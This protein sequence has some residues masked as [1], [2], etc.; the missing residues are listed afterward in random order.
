MGFPQEQMQF[1]CPTPP[2]LTTLSPEPWNHLTHFWHYNIYVVYTWLLKQTF[3][4][5]HQLL[6]CRV[7]EYLLSQYFLFLTSLEMQFYLSDTLIVFIVFK[8]QA[9]WKTLRTCISSFPTLFALEIFSA[10]ILIFHSNFIFSKCAARRH[11][12]SF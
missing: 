5:L 3:K 12:I 8:D 9:F 10:K 6:E 1:L 11:D 4:N 7:L 2:N